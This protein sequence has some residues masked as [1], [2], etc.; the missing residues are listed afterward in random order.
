MQQSDPAFY[1]KMSSIYNKIMQLVV[2]IALIIVLLNILI[3]NSVNDGERIDN[4]FDAIG[5]QYLQ[6]ANMSLQV[7]IE[8]DNKDLLEQTVNKFSALDY[9]KSVHLYNATGEVLFSSF[10]DDF[11]NDSINDLYG[12]SPNKDN[13][14][15]QYV[16]FVQEIRNEKL[17][18]YLR[19][20]IEKSQLSRVLSIASS[21][22]QKL[23]HVMLIIAGFVG[24][25]LTRGFNRFSR[26]G[27]RPPKT[28]Q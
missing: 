9:V 28:K 15:K 13:V 4:Y 1:P 21:E 19:F 27:Y 25:F 12:L 24:F 16:P 20:T 5:E 23:I 17:L 11:D 3:S 26:Q 2:A 18:G 22:R 7:L 14:S 6:Q 8:T 10:A